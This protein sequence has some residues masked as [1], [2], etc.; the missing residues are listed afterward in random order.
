[1][2][3]KILLLQKS[4]KLVGIRLNAKLNCLKSSASTLLALMTNFKTEIKFSQKTT[5]LNIDK[6]VLKQASN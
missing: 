3:F 6:P 2:A 5:T 1:M 4:F